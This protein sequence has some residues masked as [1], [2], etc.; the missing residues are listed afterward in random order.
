MSN[1]ID[2]SHIADEITKCLSEYS[3]DIAK[4]VDKAVDITAKETVRELKKT[5][6]RRSSDKPR[7]YKSSGKSY[8]AGSYAKSW[9][10]TILS[11]K[12]GNSQ[13]VVSNKIHYRLTYLLENGHEIKKGG[14]G[15]KGKGVSVGTAKAIVHIAPVEEKVISDF[16]KRVEDIIN[17]T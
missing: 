9:G 1:G 17:D 14:N 5:S 11:D 16:E 12:A 7:K 15:K 4:G 10:S 8:P 13:K 2:I 3:D 6:P